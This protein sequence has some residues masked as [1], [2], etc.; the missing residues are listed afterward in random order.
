MTYQ[1]THTAAAIPAV[2]A[3][4]MACG[5][6]VSA[7]SVSQERGTTACD[8]YVAALLGVDCPDYQLPASEIARLQSTFVPVCENAMHAQG[9][10]LTEAQLDACT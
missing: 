4:A 2:V 10:T 6:S 8:H 1:K 9:S 5:A 7:P 3:L